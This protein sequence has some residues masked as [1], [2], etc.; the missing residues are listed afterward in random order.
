MTSKSLEEP[1]DLTFAR[2][3]TFETNSEYKDK[4][5]ISLNSN[6]ESQR[7]TV[8]AKSYVNAMTA[9]QKRAKTLEEENSYMKISLNQL[10]D[11]KYKSM[12]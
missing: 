8:R 3:N 2:V 6:R 12:S 7:E 1:S 11:Q 9:L 4:E 5:N 10:R